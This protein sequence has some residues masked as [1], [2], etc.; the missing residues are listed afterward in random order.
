MN[1][2]ELID[3]DGGKRVAKPIPR[4]AAFDS[5]L[6]L[7]REGYDFISARC[8]RMNTDIFATRLMLRPA[9][10]VRGAEAAEMFYGG[11][12]FT[13]IGAMP[14]TTLRLLQDKGSVQALDGAAHR[15]RKA[16]FLSILLDGDQIERLRATFR[17]AWLDQLEDWQR[18]DEIVLFDAV[19]LVLT[20]AAAA[21]AGIPAD[22]DR[23]E[24]CRE[25]SGM[26]ENAGGI[27][28]S[29]MLA[30]WRR[31]R[32]ERTI[33]ELVRRVRSGA[34][35]LPA[36]SPVRLVSEH[37]DA[38]GKP[39]DLA[40]AAVEIINIIRPVVAIGRFIMFAALALHQH[41]QW[42][43]KFAAGD[44][45]GLE[46][47]AEEIRRLY[48]FFPFIGGRA[49]HPFEWKG[50]RF[51]QGDWVLLDLHGTNH[52]PRLFVEPDRFIPERGLSWKTHGFDFIP[53][54]GGDPATTHRCP[55]EAVTV[56]LITEAV[57]LLTRSMAYQVPDQD[58]TVSLA[59]MP[60]RP[61]SGFRID[62]V[63]RKPG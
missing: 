22:K 58:M 41:R 32:T 62:N 61:K 20:Q 56:A 8:R 34:L 38:K 60:A 59:R 13:R 52:D 24:L 17:R 35:D 63:R 12:H 26:V 28:P 7:L 19:N 33:G 1:R 10:C 11:D 43:D 53:H 51:H 5:T 18:R 37:V 42:Y 3:A 6:A 27:G 54:G 2:R 46:A 31:R 4:D 47:F 23:A 40:S 36:N 21:W 30:L 44:D 45:D 50:Y 48:P 57:R 29:T 9:I 55:G 14:Q 39:L 15:H 49:R 25:L 16:L